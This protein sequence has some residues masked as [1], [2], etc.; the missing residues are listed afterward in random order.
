MASYTFRK[1]VIIRMILSNSTK[2]CC[3]SN[4]WSYKDS[5]SAYSYLFNDSER[6]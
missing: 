4:F 1:F 5:F 6:N 2:L 3:Y